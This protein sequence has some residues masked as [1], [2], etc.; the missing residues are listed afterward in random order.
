MYMAY[1]TN[2]HLPR[3]RMQAAKLVLEKGWSTRQAARHT[4]FN[5]STIVRWVNKAQPLRSG[6]LIHTESS[7]PHS[8]P[9]QLSDELVRAIL[10]YRRKYR[11]CAE[12]IHHL[13]LKDGYRLS[14]SS[15]KRTLKKHNC[16][17]YSRWKKWHRYTPR[18]IPSKPGILV[19]ADTIWDGLARN[20]LYAYTLID[21]CSRWAHVLPAN[22]ISA[23][24]S[25]SFIKEAQGVS[26]FSFITLQ[27]DH[28]SEF[29]KHFTKLLMHQGVNHRHSRIRTP[30]DNGHLERFNRTLQEEC[31]SRIPRS[32]RVWSKEI[33][34]Y[35]SWYN[36][37]RPHMGLGMKTPLDILK[38]MQSY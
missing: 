8:H 2:P 34:E 11:R 5:Q 20:R 30:S 4:G 18:P 15:V 7:R 6:A 3:V 25:F 13:L 12:V 29:S 24:R 33:P 22:R 9:R 10:E 35:L 14:L 32:L 23:L 21:V 26:P 37:E 17:R 36:G 19:Q 28:G 31:L 38:V 16:S 27:S 1:T